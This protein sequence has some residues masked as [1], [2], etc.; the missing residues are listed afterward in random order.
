MRFARKNEQT[1]IAGPNPDSI[2]FDFY[3]ICKGKT[4]ICMKNKENYQIDM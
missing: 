2:D 4:Y 1:Q 3:A